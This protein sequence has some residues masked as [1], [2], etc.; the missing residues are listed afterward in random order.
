MSRRR[1][2]IIMCAVC[3]VA[4]AACAILAVWLVKCGYVKT[5]EAYHGGSAWG[6]LGYAVASAL[7][8]PYIYVASRFFWIIFTDFLSLM[9][10]DW[11][12]SSTVS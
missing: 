9:R 12:G 6:A 5:I 4:A 3:M 10:G 7:L 1:T 2:N 11:S 8:I